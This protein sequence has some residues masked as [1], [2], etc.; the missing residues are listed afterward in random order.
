MI[1]NPA[2]KSDR[3]MPPQAANRSAAHPPGHPLFRARPQPSPGGVKMGIDALGGPSPLDNSENIPSPCAAS[4]DPRVQ[5][6]REKFRDDLATLDARRAA[7]DAKLAPPPVDER[8][9]AIM[10]ENAR[11]L[12]FLLEVAISPAHPSDQLALALWQVL[13]LVTNDLPV[14]AFVRMTLRDHIARQEAALLADV[15]PE[16]RG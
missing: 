8:A 9:V 16:G 3:A 12:D 6:V 5:A 2:R 15:E 11:L 13:D 7:R 10:R 4:L 1:D 14:E